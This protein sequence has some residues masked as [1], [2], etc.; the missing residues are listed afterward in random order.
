MSLNPI[1]TFI[2]RFDTALTGS[3]D[4]LIGAMVTYAS[5]P[6]ALCACL[7]YVI[8]GF[9]FVQ[10]D[11]EVLHAFWGRLIKIGTLV[12]LATNLSAFNQW[13]RDFIFLGIPNAL[14][15]ALGPAM[16]AAPGTVTTTAAMFDNVWSQLWVII[17]MVWMQMGFSVTGMLAGIVGVLTALFGGGGLLVIAMVYIGARMVFAILVCL[18]PIILICG[19]FDATKGV[20]ERAIGKA[21]A[22]IILQV[23]GFIVMQIVLLGNQ[24][25]MAQATNAI[26]SAASNGAVF[27][28]AIQILLS[29]CA[30]FMA[31]AYG[32]WQIR[33]VAYSLGTG[34][35]LPGPSAY[36]LASLYRMFAGGGRNG[37]GPASPGSAPAGPLSIDLARPALTSSQPALASPA[38]P[39]ALTYSTRS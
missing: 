2:Q 39:P 22:L 17:S 8:Q 23:A 16:G 28:E 37:S 14:N 34:I 33:S 38:P 27:A 19:I 20:V 10:G 5:T 18:T 24:W 7:Y 32:M 36:A 4:G 25:F 1:G 29:I 12:W 6:I 35:M 11:T 15:V 3:I 9:K 26:I 13:I 21:I 31:G 30:W